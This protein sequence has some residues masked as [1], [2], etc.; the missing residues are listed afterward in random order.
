MLKLENYTFSTSLVSAACEMF[1]MPAI[2]SFSLV[3]CCCGM[4]LSQ[5]LLQ[6]FTINYVNSEFLIMYW[7]RIG[8]I[9]LP[10]SSIGWY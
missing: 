8:S 9:G 10:S 5:Q 6:E 7:P 4:P 2:S 1:N 3:F